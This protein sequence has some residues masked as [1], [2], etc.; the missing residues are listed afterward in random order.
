MYD[1]ESRIIKNPINYPS[2][3]KTKTSL[4]SWGGDILWT[5]ILEKRNYYLIKKVEFW[6]NYKSKQMQS[7]NSLL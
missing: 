7:V 3:K 5:K 6:I 4:T 1:G 2:G